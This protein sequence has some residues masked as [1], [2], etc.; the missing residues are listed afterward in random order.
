VVLELIGCQSKAADM[1]V[2]AYNEPEVK[3]VFATH[4]DMLIVGLSKAFLK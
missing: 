3:I 2:K 1:E 4:G